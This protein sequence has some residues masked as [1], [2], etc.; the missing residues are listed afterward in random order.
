[1]WAGLPPVTPLRPGRPRKPTTPQNPRPRLI[2]P[3]SVQLVVEGVAIHEAPGLPKAAMLHELKLVK[4]GRT[5]L[6]RQT[7]FC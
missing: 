2:T 4:N 7:T 1:M 5:A 6:A 3:R